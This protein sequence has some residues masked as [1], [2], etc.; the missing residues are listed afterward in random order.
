MCSGAGAETRHTPGAA[1]LN[2]DTRAAR[3]GIGARRYSMQAITLGRHGLWRDGRKGGG[4][5]LGHKKERRGNGEV[6]KR[7]I[8]QEGREGGGGGGKEREEGRREKCGF[9]GAE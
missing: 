5:A 3:P 1:R 7:D 2:G 6:N 8:D 9:E 4:E